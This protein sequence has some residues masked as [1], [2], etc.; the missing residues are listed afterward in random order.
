[1]KDG[2]RLYHA[3]EYLEATKIVTIA[4]S[5]LRSEKRRRRYRSK[6]RTTRN[7]REMHL[8]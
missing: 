1:M 6:K 5:W 4:F 2:E 8:L 7:E 3:L